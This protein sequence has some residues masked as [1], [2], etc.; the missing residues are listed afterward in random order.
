VSE[1]SERRVPLFKSEPEEMRVSIS[2]SEP[3]ERR[4]P[5]FKSEPG[6]VR[7]LCQ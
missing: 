2:V 4:V 1:P 7:V 3:S 6:R 5:L